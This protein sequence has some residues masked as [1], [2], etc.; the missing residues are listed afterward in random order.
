MRG[1]ATDIETA[2][3]AWPTLAGLAILWFA[4]L[5]DQ[6]WL[7]A[8]LFGGWAILDIVTGESRFIQRIT[9]QEHPAVFW[10]IVS[11]WIVMSILWVLYS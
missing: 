8:A 9:R 2:G 1:A 7:F 5:A 11:S 4:A 10:A 3:S 6:V